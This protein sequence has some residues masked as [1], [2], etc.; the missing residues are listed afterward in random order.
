MRNGILTFRDHPA[1]GTPLSDLFDVYVGLVSGKE[2]VFRVPFGNARVRI[3]KE[4][5]MNYIFP[6]TF[7]TESPEINAHLL[8][9]KTALMERKIRTFT[10]SN[11][12]E[13]GAPR[14]M[15]VM[16]SAAGRPCIYVRN[17]TR[18]SDVAFAGTV[19]K[20]GGALLCLIPKTAMSQSALQTI[21]DYLNSEPFKHEYTFSGRFKIGHKQIQNVLLPE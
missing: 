2:E 7:P 21:L 9:N 20:F 14:N 19:E 4:S 5:V 13:W 6:T 1:S 17:L 12:F 3:D 16:E 11:W 18:K 8:A 10:E 15:S